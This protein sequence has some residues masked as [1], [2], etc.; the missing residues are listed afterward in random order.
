MSLLADRDRRFRRLGLKVALFAGTALGAVLVLLGLYAGAKGYFV[1]KTP[2]RFEAQTGTDLKPGMAVKLSGFKIGEVHQVALNERARVDVQM[3]IESRYMQWIKADSVA[4]MAREGMIG[5]SYISLKSGSPDL[6]LLPPDAT[7]RFQPGETLNDIANDVRNRAVPVIDGMRELLGYI[8]DPKGDVRQ[9]LHDVRALAAELRAT[10]K[11]LDK[12]LTTTEK[13]AAED[14]TATLSAA[15]DTMTKAD[16]AIA[17]IDAAIPALQARTETA[18]TQLDA[19]TAEARQTLSTAT[20]LLQQA[21]PR[22]NQTL[23]NSNALISEARAAVQSART[24]W[25][26]AP[27]GKEEALQLTLPPEL[28]PPPLPPPLPV[29]PEGKAGQ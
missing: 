23:D 14:V 20:T 12:L 16:A 10:R 24:R 26:F 6:E 17:R 15:R 5:D 19:T 27:R 13:V 22:L 7:I 25:P 8:N 18:L 21:S 11:R 9:G 3:L 1:D 29:E 2:V 28:A 4:E